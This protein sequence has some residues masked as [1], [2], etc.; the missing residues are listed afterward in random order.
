[1]IRTLTVAALLLAGCS[2]SPPR[3]VTWFEAHA[4]EAKLV[5]EKCAAGE[6]SNECE[7]ARTGLTRAKATAR[8]ERYRKAFE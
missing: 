1:M 6:R 7:N 5:V 4:D 3:D 8:M 2:P